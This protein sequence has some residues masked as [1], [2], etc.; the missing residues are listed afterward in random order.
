MS[1]K[2]YWYPEDGAGLS[3]LTL[4][5]APSQVHESRVP[6]RVTARRGDGSGAVAVGLPLTRVRI[7][8]ERG[9]SAGNVRDLR[10]LE[11][12][13]Q[14]GGPIGFARDHTKAWAAYGSRTFRGYSY[15]STIGGNA[16][17]AWE[18]A[19]ALA[20]GDEV[21]I[22]SAPPAGEIEMHAVSSV[23]ATG[24]VNLNSETILKSFDGPI[25]VRHR[26]FYPALW[27]PDDQ[28]SRPIVTT[29]HRLTYTLDVELEVVP[30]I[31]RAGYSA[32]TATKPL[33]LSGPSVVRGAGITLQDLV[34]PNAGSVGG[35]CGGGIAGMTGP[36]IGA[37]YIG[38]RLG[39]RASSFRSP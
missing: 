3:V 13:L 29:E 31:I 2:I 9:L 28:V 26:D 38:G 36:T 19:A 23:S 5:R 32:A 22:E 14:R 27:M 18:A 25:L 21:V 11:D 34:G 20:S 39:G 8:V 33:G 37:S 17:T 10:Q 1:A 30:D 6:D 15:V 16:F 4:A 35:G 7:V 12:H 24:N